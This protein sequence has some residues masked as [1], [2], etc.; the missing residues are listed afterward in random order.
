VVDGVA[1]SVSRI[2]AQPWGAAEGTVPASVDTIVN[3]L[4]DFEHMPGTIP[5]LAAIRVLERRTG[6]A[7]VYFRYD[8]PWPLADRDYTARY[9][10]T[11]LPTGAARVEI[12]DADAG[13]PPPDRAV[14][15][16]DVRACFV[17]DPIA[18]DL[19]RVRYRVHMELGGFL[20]RRLKE[21]AMGTLALRSVLGLRRYFSPPRAGAVR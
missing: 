13:G 4:T 7:L 2:S 1:G 19:T 20:P 6:E 16:T 9:R 18:Q 15:V 11:A 10:W 21:D 17:L 5:W 12:D 14:R 3:H 8:L